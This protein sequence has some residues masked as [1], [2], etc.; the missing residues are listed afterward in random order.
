MILN[1]HKTPINALNSKSDK[2]HRQDA[3]PAAESFQMRLINVNKFLIV[4]GSLKT[5]RKTKSPY[6]LK[7]SGFI[8]YVIKVVINSPISYLLQKNANQHLGSD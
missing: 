2:R 1:L 3:R 4:V 5:N 8:N 7:F 6:L